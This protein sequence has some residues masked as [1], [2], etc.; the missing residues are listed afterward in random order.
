ML[1]KCMYIHAEDSIER[2]KFNIDWVFR[3]GAS[4]AVL[5]VSRRAART[6]ARHPASCATSSSLRLPFSPSFFARLLFSPLFFA[7]NDFHNLIP[8]PLCFSVLRR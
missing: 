5:P 6:H 7:I 1:K 4:A 3:H 2:K 8:P